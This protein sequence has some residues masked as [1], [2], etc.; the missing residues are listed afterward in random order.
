MSPE[1]EATVNELHREAIRELQEQ[2]PRKEAKHK[3]N[4]SDQ[5]ARGP[6]IQSSA[7]FTAN[8][9]PPDYLIDGFL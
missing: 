6:L 3:A 9:V 7:Q 8:Y 2:A 5:V 1:M 4:G